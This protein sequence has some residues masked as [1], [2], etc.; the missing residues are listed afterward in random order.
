VGASGAA[1][2]LARSAG[3]PRVAAASAAAELRPDIRRRGDERLC[4]QG[5]YRLA[6][7]GPHL[8]D[9]VAQVVARPGEVSRRQGRLGLSHLVRQA[10]TGADPLHRGVQGRELLG[11]GG[12]SDDNLAV[13][14]LLARL[15]QR[16]GRPEPAAAAATACTSTR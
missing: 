13:A 10:G 14:G 12:I 8:C 1:R 5:V 4:L 3:P 6:G 16:T 7:L 15:E 11:G 2:A 9:K